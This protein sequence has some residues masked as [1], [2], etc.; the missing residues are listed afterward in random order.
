MTEEYISMSGTLKLVTPFDENK[1]EVLAFIS[2][3]DTAF[4]VIKDD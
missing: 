3:I 1:W 4:E 2:N